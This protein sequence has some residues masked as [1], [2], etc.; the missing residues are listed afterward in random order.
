MTELKTINI[1]ERDYVLIKTGRAQAEQVI[2][3]T[4]WASKHGASAFRQ[5]SEDGVEVTKLGGAELIGSLVGA[6]NADALID[7]FTAIVGCSPEISEEHFDIATLVEAA[8]FVYEG[9]PAIKRLIDRFFSMPS[10]STSLVEDSTT[11]EQPTDG[12]TTK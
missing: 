5:L 6:L 10:S 11:S 9:Q 2:L 8:I 7:L 1:A 4:R 12:Q 3:L